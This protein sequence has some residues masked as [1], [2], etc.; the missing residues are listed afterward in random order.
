VL[1]TKRPVIINFW[2]FK[3]AIFSQLFLNPQLE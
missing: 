2:R 3:L 1:I